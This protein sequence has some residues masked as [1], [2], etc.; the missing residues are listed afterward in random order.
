MSNNH[1]YVWL[2]MCGDRY[3]P[4]V[5][6]SAYSVK[7]TNPKADLVVMVTPDVTQESVT[8]ISKLAKVV[9]VDYITFNGKFNHVD[10]L[11][12]Y[13]WINLSY[14][15]W[16][17]LGLPYDKIFMLDTDIIVTK[18][19]DEVF[20]YPAPAGVFQQQKPLHNYT[21][22]RY[23]DKR[24]NLPEKTTLL[25]T[26]IEK[27]LG[28]KNQLLAT[29]TSML[30]EP[31]KDVDHFIR[32]ISEMKDNTYPNTTGIDEQAIA[33]YMSVILKKSWMVL[34]TKYNAV[35][36]W[37]YKNIIGHV[38][39]KVLHFMT[40]EKPWERDPTEFPELM[41]WAKVQR[42]AYNYITSNYITSNYNTSKVPKVTDRNEE[43]QD[44]VQ[45]GQ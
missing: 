43:T 24:N 31:T 19:I 38:Y 17:C 22:A 8:Q 37:K 2:V 9:T 40:K 12:K 34:D 42:E 29:A 10:P 5:I 41:M 14:T 6:T 7:K 44:P 45:P 36:W 1:A 30:L 28:T 25:P 27:L 16:R 15:K 32:S 20:L 35:P 33:Y 26:D 18:N 4:G 21:L 3:V 39:G 11:G 23:L 13:S